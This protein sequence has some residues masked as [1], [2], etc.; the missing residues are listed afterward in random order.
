MQKVKQ[1]L[2]IKNKYTTMNK[3]Y[4]IFEKQPQMTIADVERLTE[5]GYLVASTTTRKWFNAEDNHDMANKNAGDV[6]CYT[7]LSRALKYDPINQDDAKRLMQ[8]EALRVNGAPRE[9]I[10]NRLVVAA[11]AEDRNNALSNVKQARL[12]WAQSQK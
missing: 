5:R 12:A 7:L 9:N 10:L 1:F 6:V 4:N 8:V 11:F 2:S 3:E